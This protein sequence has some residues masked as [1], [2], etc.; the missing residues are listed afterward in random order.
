MP[1]INSPDAPLR[2]FW[3]SWREQVGA[4]LDEILTKEQEKK[5]LPFKNIS[6]AAKFSAERL[7]FAFPD[8]KEPFS[9]STLT[10]NE[11]YRRILESH[12]EHKNTNSVSSS[13]RVK[14]QLQIRSQKKE[15]ADL[16]KI[17]G[18]SL[19]NRSHDEK[20]LSNGLTHDAADRAVEESF[21]IWLRVIDRLLGEIEGAA[22]DTHKRT[23]EDPDGVG[24]LLAEKD[25][26][27]GFFDW[28]RRRNR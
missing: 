2:E 9:A 6:Q 28:L 11:F 7:T 12:V 23:I 21:S 18:N 22:I 4:K 3:D 26:P 1:D 5:G 15:L 27:R 8:K 17:I 20:R 14:L 24:T 16:K 25:F 13:E 10:R 19:E